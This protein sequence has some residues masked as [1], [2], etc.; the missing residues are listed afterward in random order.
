M[1]E[2]ERELQEMLRSLNELTDSMDSDLSEY[3]KGQS[4][5]VLQGRCKFCMKSDNS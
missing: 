1:I 5:G 2:N 4:N 3:K